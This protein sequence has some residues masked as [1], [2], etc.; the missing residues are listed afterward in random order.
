ME[1]VCTGFYTRFY[2]TKHHFWR[3]RCGGGG[4]GGGGGGAGG[5][6]GSSSGAASGSEGSGKA[7]TAF[8]NG[9]TQT[10][11]PGKNLAGIDISTQQGAKEAIE[12]L[13]A[14]QIR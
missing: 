13:N 7:I 1:P 12:V 6:G 4:G 5:G 9:A 2:Y 3:R 14:A 10:F 11:V 8:V